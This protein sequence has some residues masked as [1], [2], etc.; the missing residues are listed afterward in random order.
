MATFLQNGKV[1]KMI[2]IIL[3][4]FGLFLIFQ[5]IRKMFGG[6]WS[7]EDIIIGLLLFNTGAILTIGMIVAELKSDYKH[8]DN[9]V[10]KIEDQLQKRK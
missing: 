6:S 8:I 10:Q 4:L 1:E 3:V 2:E 9:R 5:L 7:V